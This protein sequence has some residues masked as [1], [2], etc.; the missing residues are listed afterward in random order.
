MCR[1]L[2]S[3]Q[4]TCTKWVV[5]FEQDPVY[6]HWAISRIPHVH[7]WPQGAVTLAQINCG[8]IEGV[9]IY[10]D[11]TPCNVNMHCVLEKRLTRESLRAVYRYPFIQLGVRRITALIA[12][13]N[14]KSRKLAQN[15]GFEWE[16][17]MR[18]GIEDDDLCVYGL[19]KEDCRYL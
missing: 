15:A 18:H 19:L 8:Q 12:W 2:G 10:T 9:A 17:L 3:P 11:Y 5:S 4:T 16:G 7:S 14:L 13:R 6:L 1:S